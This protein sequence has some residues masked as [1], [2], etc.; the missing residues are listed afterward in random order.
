[1]SNH[2]SSGESGL[3]K[4]AKGSVVP[5]RRFFW[6]LAAFW[7]VTAAGSLGWNLKHNAKELRYITFQ[8]A[9]ALLEKDLLY[10]E[11]SILHGGVYIPPANDPAATADPDEKDREIVTLTG[12]RL[13]LLN[14]ALV[15]RQVFKLQDQQMGVR[16]HITSLNPVKPANRPDAWERQALEAFANGAKEVSSVEMVAGQ[17]Q[18]RMMR[19]LVTVPSCL[20]C[21]EESG[22]KPG[23]IRGGI[24]V[25]VP[26]EQFAAQGENLHLAAAH[27][28]LWFIGFTG[29][30]LG[31]RNLEQHTVQQ[32]LAE[33]RTE[34]ALKEKEALLQEIHHRVKNNLQ[35]ISSLLQLQINELKDPE[36]VAVF[37][38]SQLRVRSMALIHEKLYQSDSL[39]RIDAADYLRSLT[40]LLFSTYTSER[41]RV[42]LDLQVAPAFLTINT[43]IPLGLIANELIT[44]CLKFAFPPGRQGTVRVELA[45]AANGAF[46]FRVADDGVGFPETF[47][48]EK[49]ASLGMRLVRILTQQLD[50]HG[51]WEQ[52]ATGT[53]FVMEFQDSGAAEEKSSR[54][55]RQRDVISK[56]QV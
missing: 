16:G 13:T 35:V 40:T 55:G 4:E 29:L 47:G 50:A 27:G 32:K 49:S 31:F 38:E 43:A 8:T 52:P 30:V 19:P 37:Q 51:T 26:M 42:G 46:R 22:R 21:H 12:Q 48:A 15:S 18:F 36:T 24:S 44:N 10:R 34:A 5:Y 39:A 41:G 6:V 7:T 3:G 11:W 53:S 33:Q 9:Q 2:A 45:E 54:P 56:M 28:G 25:T 1:V 14:P 23:E 17:R 20:H